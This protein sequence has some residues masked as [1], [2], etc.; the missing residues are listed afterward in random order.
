MPGSGSVR[1]HRQT[2]RRQAAALAVARL[3]APMIG[4]G[5]RRPPATVDALEGT[6]DS[7][8]RVPKGAGPVTAGAARTDRS[9]TSGIMAP[10]L[11]VSSSGDETGPILLVDDQPANLDALEASLATSGCRFVLART[12]DEA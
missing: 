4:G 12:A 6:G 8:R 2:G 11:P 7:A 5:V 3:V 1:L 10:I 9:G